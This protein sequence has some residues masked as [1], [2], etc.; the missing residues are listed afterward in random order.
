MALFWYK[1]RGIWSSAGYK[2]FT[3]ETKAHDLFKYM[4]SL[5]RKISTKTI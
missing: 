1:L 2:K 5:K 4:E 3:V